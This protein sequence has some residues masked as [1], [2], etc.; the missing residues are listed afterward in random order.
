MHPNTTWKRIWQSLMCWVFG[1]SH[2]VSSNAPLFWFS[3]SWP[4]PENPLLQYHDLKLHSILVISAISPHT[5]VH[6]AEDKLWGFCCCLRVL[7]GLSKWSPDLQHLQLAWLI[8]M[9]GWLPSV[10]KCQWGP[11]GKAAALRKLMNL[12]CSRNRLSI[13]LCKWTLGG[14]ILAE[15]PLED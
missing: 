5:S 7:C 2:T 6:L 15:A 12:V 1:T 3:F 4:H 8:L 10:K 11:A 13:P 9:L 14:G